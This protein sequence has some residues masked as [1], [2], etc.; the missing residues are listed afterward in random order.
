MVKKYFFYKKFLCYQIQ[1]SE[2]AIMNFQDRAAA[3]GDS[4]LLDLWTGRPHFTY[5]WVPYSGSF[6]KERIDWQM[7]ELVEK[8][9]INGK[10]WKPGP[11]RP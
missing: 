11:P 2:S 3:Y 8:I 4:R 9:A 7:M 1:F 5:L 10:N 6:G